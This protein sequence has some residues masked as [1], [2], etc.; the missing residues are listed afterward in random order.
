[1]WSQIVPAFR[2]TLV[3][4]ILTGLIYPAV[5]TGIAQAIFPKQAHGSLVT[6]GGTVV[7]SELLGQ[8]FSRPEYFHPRPSAAGKD[9]YDATASSGSNYGPTNQKLI[10]RVKASVEQY[11][12]QNPGYAGPIPADA[13]TASGSGLDPHISPRNAEIQSTR[14]AHA[15]GVDEAA[16]K[17][18]VTQAIEAPWLGF[19]GEPR[20]NVL[21]LNLALDREF[22]GR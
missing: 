3:L 16:V 8:N 13:V 15:R 22:G 18:L 21:R 20:V 11:R 2:I 10:E 19:N 6:V 14:V 9:G 17:R 1:M 5:V 7:G 4:T 12:K